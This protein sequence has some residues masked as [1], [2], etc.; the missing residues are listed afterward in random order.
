MGLDNSVVP[1]T[2]VEFRCANCESWRM[3]ALG[4][5]EIRCLRCNHLIAQFMPVDPKQLVI[6]L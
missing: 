4:E 2:L 3:V 6:P 1:V 5:G